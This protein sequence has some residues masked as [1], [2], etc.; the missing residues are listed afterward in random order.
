MKHIIA[1]VDSS[2]KYIGYFNEE[3][4]YTATR[5]AVKSFLIGRQSGGIDSARFRTRYVSV[6]QAWPPQGNLASINDD[7]A[8]A[9]FSRTNKTQNE[10]FPWRILS[11]EWYL[12]LSY[13]FGVSL[14]A[15]AN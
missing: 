1:R 4:S 14:V 9:S 10:N 11:E 8:F 5:V 13:N 2:F 3:R 12:N 15:S 7:C 6:T